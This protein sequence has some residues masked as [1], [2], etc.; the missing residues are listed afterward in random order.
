LDTSMQPDPLAQQWA[1]L[2]MARYLPMPYAPSARMADAM[3]HVL[4]DAAA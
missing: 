2:M 4:H 3:R 1:R